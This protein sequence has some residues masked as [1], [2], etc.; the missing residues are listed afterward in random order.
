MPLD[1]RRQQLKIQILAPGGFSSVQCR[2]EPQRL[3]GL[4]NAG[5]TH[6]GKRWFWYATIELLVLEGA[7]CLLTSQIESRAAAGLVVTAS[8]ILS[9]MSS[10][11]ATASSSKKSDIV[12]IAQHGLR[13][14]SAY[15]CIQLYSCTA[16]TAV[17]GFYFLK[18]SF[19]YM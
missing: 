16:F 4:D 18:V 13:A 6:G 11:A 8:F 17:L 9:S 10:L 14:L 19:E 2:H 3:P 12:E 5:G 15:S 1:L 7:V